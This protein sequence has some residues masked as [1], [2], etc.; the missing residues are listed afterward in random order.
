MVTVLGAQGERVH[1]RSQYFREYNY[2]RRFGIDMAAYLRMFEEQGGVCAICGRPERVVHWMTGQVM[3]LAV[4]HDHQTGEV[5]GLL[6]MN[7]N[8]RLE[9]YE[10]FRANKDWTVKAQKYLGMEKGNTNV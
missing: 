6:C 7:C 3:P 10:R 5:R 2:R 4:D 1:P 9:K 8:T